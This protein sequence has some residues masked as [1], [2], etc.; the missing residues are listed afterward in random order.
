MKIGIIGAGAEG[1]GLGGLL[2]LEEDV[3]ELRL[4]DIHE[5][6]LQLSLSRIQG[7]GKATLTKGSIVDAANSAEVA[8][9]GRG[10]DTI[11]NATLPTFNLAVMHGC[12]EARA[13]YVDLNSGP[14]EVEGLIPYEHTIDAQFALNDAFVSRRLTA[15][16]CAGVAPGWVD[17][18]AR[19]ATERLDEVDTVMVRWVEWNDGS[20]LVSSVG[21]GLIANFNMPT[22]MVWDNG[23]VSTVDLFDSE[24]IYSGPPPYTVLPFIRASCIRRC[25]PCGT[26]RVLS[27]TSRSRVVSQWDG[28]AAHV[29]S[30][31][32]HCADSSS[33]ERSVKASR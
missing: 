33:R 9:W 17:L 19:Y 16:S 14:F 3:E 30:G 26:C 8:E 2:V 10:L 13:H 11:V 20:D 6:R 27:A 28:G 1:S 15:V 32:R 12:L 7:L 24:E 29:T 5:G 31:S 25:E 22:P 21:P 23:D 18:A 4:A